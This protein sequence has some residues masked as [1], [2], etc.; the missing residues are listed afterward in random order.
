MA[1]FSGCDRRVVTRTDTPVSGKAVVAVDECL[2]P[3]INEEI[4]AF[5]GLNPE[6]S[7]VPIY[8]TE[9]E[10]I[11]L[12]V[13]DSVRM[14]VTTRALS[15][16]E[17]L[18]IKN[19]KLRLRFQVIAIDGIALIVNKENRD[20]LLSA[21]QLKQIM[22]GEIT[23]WKQID[24]TST[25]GN[26]TVVF[27]SPNSSTV[28]Y[29]S[30]SL[31]LGQ[32]LSDRVRAIGQDTVTSVKTEA[33]N[34]KVIEYVVGHPDA[35]GIIGVNWI[36]SQNDTANFGF[37]DKIRVVA[38]SRADEATTENSY[39]PY[40]GR[41]ALGD[42]PLTRNVYMLLTDV[43]GGLPSGF[44]AFVAGEKGQRIILKAGLRP[45]TVPTRVI[46]VRQTLEK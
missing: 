31:C 1:L 23:S 33:A 30:D 4:N 35:L 9:K 3:I 41:I 10:A 19:R 14:A 20:T 18:I 34:Q 28:R 11:D 7:I 22:L 32:T 40:A 29:I 5:Q 43:S 37:I 25:R 42:Y 15:D 24:P 26:I 36:S 6:A 39:L 17:K 12:L 13:N 45:Q 46:Q 27:D 16:N 38:L 8:T 2:A 21:G 44:V